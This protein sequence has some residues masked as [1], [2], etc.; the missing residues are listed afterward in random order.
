[1][2]CGVWP[3]AR[4]RLV[5]L[6]LT[7][8]AATTALTPLTTHAGQWLFDRDEDPTDMLRTH[9]ERGGWMIYFAVALLIV[10]IML[11]GLHLLERRSDKRWLAA[12][13]VVA[14]VALAVRISSIISVIR[15]GDAGSRAVWGGELTQAN[16][17]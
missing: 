6:V 2:I 7:L 14:T 13:I 15:I 1:M 3:A 8:A 16:E 10:A 12:N 17:R 4:R 9:A 5:L 11:A